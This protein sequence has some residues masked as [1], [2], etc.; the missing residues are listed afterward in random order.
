MDPAVSLVQAYFY[1]NGYFTVTEYPVIEARRSGGYR[2]LTDL[3]V[4]AVRFPGT[5]RSYPYGKDTY[6]DDIKV[7]PHDPKLESRDDCIEFVI[8]EVKE[9]RAELN[10]GAVDPGVLRTALSRFGAFEPDNIDRIVEELGREGECM[11]RDGVRIR[12]FAF[13]STVGSKGS[14]KYSV[15]TLEHVFDYFIKQFEEYIDVIPAAQFKDP[16]MGMLAVFA[17]AKL[18][19][20]PMRRKQR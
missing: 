10:R 8:A 9:G 4:L 2:S 1:A 19:R 3:D 6:A 13:G 7:Q 16:A 11:P 15:I 5:R 12:L 20:N 17:K 14:R 18:G